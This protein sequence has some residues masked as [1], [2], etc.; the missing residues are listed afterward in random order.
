[1]KCST[2]I[3]PKFLRYTFNFVFW[4]LI[5]LQFNSNLDQWK[6]WCKRSN[7]V[8][9]F[10]I[11]C[12]ERGYEGARWPQVIAKCMLFL[13]VS[14]FIFLVVRI[15]SERSHRVSFYSLVGKK[16]NGLTMALTCF[17]AYYNCMLKFSL[18]L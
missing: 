7:K 15:W 16:V 6:Y 8:S 18:F 2:S 3:I 14:C 10:L 1:M 17:F 9:S 11:I 4:H 12:E 5:F 13:M